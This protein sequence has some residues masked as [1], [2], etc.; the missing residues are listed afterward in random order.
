MAKR[1]VDRMAVMMVST[2]EKMEKACD[3]RKREVI[4]ET[5]A[6][7]AAIGCRTRTPTRTC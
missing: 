3:A 1:M 5:A 4:K 6:K 7:P 2:S